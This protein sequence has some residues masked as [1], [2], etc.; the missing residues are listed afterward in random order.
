MKSRT[1]KTKTIK[2]LLFPRKGNVKQIGQVS[3]LGLQTYLPRLP[4]KSKAEGKGSRMSFSF[5]LLPFSFILGFR[6]WL[7]RAAFVALTVAGQQ[8]HSPKAKG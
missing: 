5:I 3:W 1:T 8:R 2:P 7:T 6:Q 4:T